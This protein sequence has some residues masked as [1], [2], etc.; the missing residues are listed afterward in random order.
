VLSSSSP[1]DAVVF[2]VVLSS[3][4]PLLL[5]EAAMSPIGGVEQPTAI[6][7]PQATSETAASVVFIM[8]AF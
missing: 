7:R 8:A 6:A 2:F 4:S 1:L 3:S 5:S